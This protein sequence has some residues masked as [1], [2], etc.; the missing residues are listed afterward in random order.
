MFVDGRCNLYLWFLGCWCY[1]F[2]KVG[3]SFVFYVVSYGI[4]L[5]GRRWLI[6]KKIE[7]SLF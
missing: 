2:G 6:Y 7:F 3:D 4:V 1:E 5:D